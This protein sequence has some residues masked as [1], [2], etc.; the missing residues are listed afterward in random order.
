MDKTQK[1]EKRWFKYRIYNLISSMTSVLGVVLIGLLLYVGFFTNIFF[2][3][4]FFKKETIQEKIVVEKSLDRK[5]KPLL[6][7]GNNIEENNISVASIAPLVSIAPLASLKTDEVVVPLLVEKETISLAPVIPI[8]DME[9]EEQSRHSKKRVVKRVTTIK[10][11]QAKRATFL[12]TSELKHRQGS[13]DTTKLKKI[14][15]TSSSA[16]Y[17]ETMKAKFAKSKHPRE[18]L[19]LAKAFYSKGEYKESEKW[20]LVSNK[21]ESKEVDSWIVFASSKAKMGQKDE[22]IKILFTYYKKERSEKVK[23]VIEKI[24]R[25]QL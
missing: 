7:E 24:K 12:T 9:R 25:G 17:I 16:N 21:L 20:A 5:E 3:K 18:A 19:L 14:N 8:V 22:A 6:I 1:L 23:A 10:T 11:V 13:R 15:L 4:N 2:D